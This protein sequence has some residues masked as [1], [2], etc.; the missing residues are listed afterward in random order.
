MMMMMM[1]MMKEKKKRKDCGAL[2]AQCKGNTCSTCIT[3]VGQ[4]GT[5]RA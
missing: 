4:P 2:C 5:G 3:H 1:M